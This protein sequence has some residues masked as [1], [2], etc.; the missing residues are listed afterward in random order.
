MYTIEK[1]D[2]Y[3]LRCKI[4]AFHN[5]LK[6]GYQAEGYKLRSA[7]RLANLIAMMYILAWRGYD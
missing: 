5:D 3:A 1:L 4:D 2:W 6:S 7:E